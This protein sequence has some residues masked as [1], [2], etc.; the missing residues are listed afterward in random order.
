MDAFNGIRQSVIKAKCLSAYIRNKKNRICMHHIE[1]GFFSFL[2]FF[3][4]SNAVPHLIYLFQQTGNLMKMSRHFV[5]LSINLMVE[6][7]KKLINDT[8]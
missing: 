8:L 5:R 1:W 7:K 2:L 4:D 6:I 3:F